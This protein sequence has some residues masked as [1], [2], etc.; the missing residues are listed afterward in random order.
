MNSQLI[1]CRSETDLASFQKKNFTEREAD[2]LCQVL[3]V[4]PSFTSE[5]VLE[6]EKARID[7]ISAPG[8]EPV[9][10]ALTTDRFRNAGAFRGKYLEQGK[11]SLS[12][13]SLKDSPLLFSSFPVALDLLLKEVSPLQTLPIGANRAS[14]FEIVLVDS[15]GVEWVLPFDASLRLPPAF[16]QQGNQLLALF[17]RK[18]LQP[19]VR[20]NTVKVAFLVDTVAPVVTKPSVIVDGGVLSPG[21]ITEIFWQVEEAGRVEAQ[22]LEWRALGEAEWRSLG[23]VPKEVRSVSMPWSATP[24][25]LGALEVRVS[26][27]DAQGLRGFASTE[28]REQFFNAAVLTKSVECFWCHMEISGHVAGIF[29]SNASPKVHADTGTNLAVT[30]NFFSNANFP[31]AGMPAVFPPERRKANYANTELPIFPK[32]NEWPVIDPEVLRVRMNGYLKGHDPVENKAVYIDRVL[33][34]NVVLKGTTQNPLVLSGEVFIDGDLV[35]SGQYKGIGTLYARNVFIV[36]DLVAVDSPYPYP[37]EEQ[38]ALAAGREAVRTKKDALYLA[39]LSDIVVGAPE[40]RS[41]ETCSSQDVTVGG[42]LFKNFLSCVSNMP[43]DKNVSGKAGARTIAHPYAWLPKGVFQSLGRRAE[44]PTVTAYAKLDAT[45]QKPMR[46]IMDSSHYADETYDS[47]GV[48]KVRDTMA[49]DRTALEVSR[50]DAFLYATEAF[51]ARVYVNLVI[52][53]GV[54]SPKVEMFS[55][56]ANSS[57]GNLESRLEDS[58]FRF[59]R[60]DQME[61]PALNERNG[62]TLHRNAI[63]YDW[64]LRTGGKGLGV[65]KEF[66]R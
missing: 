2:P 33:S 29:P 26:A 54:M 28:W 50:V 7:V 47:G 4:G 21:A 16:E 19:E 52:N 35:I 58:T 51:Q 53:G 5:G 17:A 22:T 10:A 56:Y 64:R 61:R 32:N 46:V 37:D 1:V 9:F 13:E 65:L 12:L 57:L 3:A 66:F 62:L 23:D 59:G 40:A 63:R 8:Q 48:L 41:S 18:V 55:A 20:S 43:L 45:I 44:P 38:A 36:D 15:K 30:G 42:K 14:E 24:A 27:V 11:S 31:G 60:V 39:A 49:T 6:I 34:G 25:K